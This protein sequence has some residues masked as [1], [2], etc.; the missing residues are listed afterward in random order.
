MITAIG[1]VGTIA[2]PA[3]SLLMYFRVSALY[4][5]Q[6][7]VVA[8]FTFLWIATLAGCITAPFSLK[9]IHIG[10]TQRCIDSEVKGYGSAGIVISAVNDTLIFLAITYKLV[11]YHIASESWSAR[12]TSFWKGEGMGQTSKLLL[13]TGQLYYLYVPC[14]VILYILRNLVELLPV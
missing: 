2:V 5:H 4:A 8:A 1:A 13:K 11:F 7:I 3:N 10:T 12:A 6:K 14:I 9:A